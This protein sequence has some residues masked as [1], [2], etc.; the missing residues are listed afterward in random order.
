MIHMQH[1][2]HRFSRADFLRLGGASLAGAG[3]LGLY[4]CGGGAGGGEV[5]WTVW[6]NPGELE[7]FREFTDNFNSEHKNVQAKLR[8]IPNVEEYNSKILTQLNGGTAPDVFYSFDNSIGRFIENGTITELTERLNSSKS[9]SN[10]DEFF[11]SLWGGARTEDGKIYGVPVDCNPYVIWYNKKVLRDAGIND[12][13]VDLFENGDWKWDTFQSMTEQVRQSGKT[14]YV[15]G[16]GFETYSWVTTNGGQLYDGD[17]FVQNEDP[18]SVEAYQF[19]YD[20]TQNKNFTYSATLPSGQ[21]PDALFLSN[22]LAFG[23][24]GRWWLPIF[25]QNEN[26]EFDV[27]P[28]P[29]NTDNDTEPVGIPAAYMVM[30]NDTDIPDEAFTFLTEFVS[31]EGQVFRLQGQGNAV[32][33]VSGADEVVLNSDLPEHSQF[34][35]DSRE[36][37]YA[38]PAVESRVSGLAEDITDMLEPVFVEKGDI[39][40]TL[41]KVAEMANK[42]IQEQ[43]QG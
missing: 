6:G 39:E 22:R 17:R 19:L 4:G 9:K 13:P 26:L 42:R 35:L 14:G 18:K 28:W 29:T 8:P 5:E 34:F 20:N 27:V 43:S 30:N 11:D 38:Y 33:A 25:K 7:R 31:K 12:D 16:S 2:G 1:D 21:G 10:P 37:G 23:N 36:T 41:D 24:A 15:F 40:A 32:P 3:L